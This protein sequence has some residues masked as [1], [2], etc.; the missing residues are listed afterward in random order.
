VEAF[1]DSNDAGRDGAFTGVWTPVGHETLSGL[2][3]IQ[4]KFTSKRD[5][6]LRVSDLSDELVKVKRLV[7]DGRCDCY[8]L[9]TNA[10]LSG[11]QAVRV[12][13][14]YKSAGVKEFLPYGSTWICQQIQENKRLRMLVPRVYGLGDLSQILDERAYAQARALLDSLREDLSKVVVTGAYKR[15][16][17]ALDK[18]GFVLRIG[19]PAAGK[20]TIASLLSMASLDQWHASTL[21]LDDPGMVIEHWNADEPSQFF[22]VDDAFGVTQYESYL[23]HRWN[24]ILPQVRTMLRRGAKIVMTSRDYIYNRARKD[25]KESAFPLMRES[26]VVIDVHDLTA[27]EKRQILYNH[28]KLGRQPKAFLTKVKPHLEHVAAH[29]RFVPETARR[30]ADPLFTDGLRIDRYNLEW[31][32]EKQER[33]LQ[34]VLNGLDSESKAALA[35]I[36]MRNDHLE[37]PI[38]IQESERRALERMGSSLGGCVT[39]LDSLNGSLVQYAHV[40]GNSIWRFKHPT[41]GDAFA[42]LLI[43]NPELLEVYL[44]GSP[45]EKLIYQVT[46]GDVGLEKAVV[47]S[48][49]LFPQMLRR[50][51]EFSATTEYKS[52]WLSSWG[53]R[54][55]LYGFLARRCSKDFLTLFVEKQPE[56]PDRVSEPGL[57][58]SAVSEVDLAVRLHEYGL[59][60]EDRR[61][62]FISTVSAYAV[63]GEDLYALE[64]RDMRRVFTDAEFEEL[65]LR[66]RYELLPRLDDVSRNWQTNHS[67]DESAENQMQPLLDSFLTLTKEFSDDLEVA[68]IVERETERIN[69]W[70]A[71]HTRNDRDDAPKRTLGDVQT[72]DEFKD[73]RSIFEDVDA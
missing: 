58:L 12:E 45:T 1:L 4:C 24:H 37:S 36:Y 10:G 23:V 2:F 8:I 7:N 64:D 47:I 3:V 56:I 14:L 62:K 61:Q 27:D 13:K 31:F 17:A 67:E 70:I 35:L 16:A 57:F 40:G 38:E 49:A 72:S 39:A 21:K 30:I 5:Y 69:V 63:R 52:P 71:E 25:L 22:W 59:L 54:D 41:I 53:A 33:F 43:Q 11:K 65:R 32:V 26:Q 50:L 44:Q 60:P 20:T 28:L 48:K 34:E 19:E 46:C 55:R 6:N 66:V 68:K 18:H 51:N 9:L 15:A 42:G 73:E 29:S